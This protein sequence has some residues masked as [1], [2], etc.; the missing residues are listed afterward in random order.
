MFVVKEIKAGER[1][2]KDN[3]CSIWSGYDM[4]YAIHE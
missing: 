3:V 2:T 1:F 4:A